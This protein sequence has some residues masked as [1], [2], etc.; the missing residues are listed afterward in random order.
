VIGGL[1]VDLLVLA[2][3]LAFAWGAALLG[4]L[5][6]LGRLVESA[7]AFLVAV[8]LRDPVGDL[9][10]AIAGGS[11]DLTNL[12]GMLLVAL[13]TWVAVNRLYRWWRSRRSAA[14]TG[15]D[16]LPLDDLPDRL[17]SRL[18]AR[19][20]GGLLGLGWALLFVALLVLQPSDNVVSRSA[21][22]SRT[23][24]VQIRRAH[25]LQ[26]LRDGFP[27]Y[28]QSLPKGTLGA[29]VGERSDLPMRDPVR[30]GEAR[31][32][33]DD[34]LRAIN[35]LRTSARVRELSFN[36]DVASVARRQAV[37]L[38]HDQR[39]GYGPAG[40]GSLAPRVVAA[41][42]ESS[43]A[44]DD[45]VGVETAWAHDP[46]TAMR[47]LLDSSR[48]RSLLRDARW[49]EIGIGTV[50]AGWFNGRIYVLLLVGPV[51]EAEVGAGGA[52]AAAGDAA[53]T[54][55]ASVTDDVADDEDEDVDVDAPACL[56]TVECP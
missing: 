42:G 22:A 36:P 27:H 29:V 3:V 45:E 50:D 28:T 39:L 1:A 37:G 26:W 8:L 51:D 21:V 12:V 5:A 32:D 7:A 11:E 38:A 30:T 47:G 15:D 18:V 6:A 53:T 54:D 41:L 14:R 46:A 33:A 56:S 35:D 2:A 48:A 43:G 52:A 31:G 16:G 55:P 17:D 24:G 44:F 34:L 25:F 49:S 4:G 20:A 23:G 13:G 19:V 10:H 40:G 9:V